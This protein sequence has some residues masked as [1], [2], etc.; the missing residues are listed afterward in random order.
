VPEALKVLLAQK[1][2]YLKPR[3]VQDLIVAEKPIIV[4][5]LIN[6]NL[7]QSKFDKCRW[8]KKDLN[9]YLFKA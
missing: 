1:Y 4:N 3:F 5:E 8:D 6:T 2:T 9:F 7:D